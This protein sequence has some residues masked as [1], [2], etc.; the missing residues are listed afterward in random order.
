MIK[1]K[2][3]VVLKNEGISKINTKDIY[4]IS[5]KSDVYLHIALE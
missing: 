2:Q 4:D 3:T 5:K 1:P